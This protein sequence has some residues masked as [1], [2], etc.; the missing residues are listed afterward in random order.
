MGCNMVKN[1]KLDLFENYNGL[2]PRTIGLFSMRSNRKPDWLKQLSSAAIDR[3]FALI[4]LSL[5]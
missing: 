3:F 5:F 1:G 2:A 4:S